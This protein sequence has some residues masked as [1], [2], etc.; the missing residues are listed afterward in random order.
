MA[1]AREQPNGWAKGW[2]GTDVGWVIV[3]TIISGMAT[4]G[5]IGYGLDRLIGTDKV[6]SGVGIV[7]GAALGIYIVYLRFGRQDRGGSDRA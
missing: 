3:G 2:A 7:V 1:A 6:L 5:A 4:M